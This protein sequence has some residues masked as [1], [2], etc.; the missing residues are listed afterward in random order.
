MN[1]PQVGVLSTVLTLVLIMSIAP[2]FGQSSMSGMSDQSMGNLSMGQMSYDVA[3]GG[4]HFNVMISSTGKLPT[5][6]QFDMQKKSIAFDVS[7]I[8][9]QDF[10]HYEVTMPTDL[11]SGNLTVS[12]GGMQ[13][14]AIAEVNGSSTAV[15]INVPSSFVKSNN[16]A[17]STTLTITG[18]QAIP[19][20]PI[21][22]SITMVIA[23]ATFSIVLIRN[24]KFSFRF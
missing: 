4:K 3:A 17:D 13:V 19:E 7:G 21:S 16:I 23:F 10:V 24:N 14:K 22:A 5:N 11:L 2:T 8:T 20:F 12:L 9:S 1:H 6:P 15:H 18:T